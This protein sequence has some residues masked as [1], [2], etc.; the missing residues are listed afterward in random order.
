MYHSLL[1]LFIDADT[2]EDGP[3][4]KA[5]FSKLFDAAAT[6]P[7]IYEYAPA[8]FKLYK[9]EAEDAARQNNVRLNGS[10]IHWNHEWR[11]V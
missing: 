7:R 11:L 4:S 1:Q 8:D 3:V 5:S 6:L 10:E 2:N 9:T